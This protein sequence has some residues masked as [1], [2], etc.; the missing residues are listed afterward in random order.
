MS[1]KMT[2]LLTGRAMSMPELIMVFRLVRTVV[3]SKRTTWW[4][5]SLDGERW[6]HE[7]ITYHQGTVKNGLIV[8]VHFQLSLLI[9][10]EVQFI[11]NVDQYYL[12]STAISI[13]I[14]SDILFLK[15]KFLFR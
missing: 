11:S 12:L 2:E 8:A 14:S 6:T 5:S 7:H 1:R 15:I 4:L 13:R 10:L 9:R 3:L